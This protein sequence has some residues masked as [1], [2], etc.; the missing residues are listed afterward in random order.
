MTLVGKIFTVLVLIMSISFMMLAVTVFATHRNWQ[1]MVTDP[2]GLKSQIEALSKTNGELRDEIVRA[3]DQIAL[4][5]AARRFALAAGQ[6]R[7]EQLDAALERRN[8]E[9][10]DLQAAHGTIVETLDRNQNILE[11]LTKENEGLRTEIRTAQQARDDYFNQVVMLTDSVNRMEGN[12]RTLQEQHDMLLV[13]NGK[14]AKVMRKFEISVDT[15][16]DGI[17]PRVDGYVIAV[18]DTNLI[19]ISIGSDD[20]LRKNHFM[21]VY[22]KNSYVGRVEIVMVKPDRAVAK[23][24]PEFRQGIIRKGDRVAAK[25][26]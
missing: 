16:V 23:I 22:R 26:S 17:T 14:M 18:N 10:T 15:P 25:L 7:L 13:Q 1:A 24:I 21:E 3:K 2:G 9:Y 4:E 8:Q 12:S 6:A 5:Q 20:G 11:S 19:E